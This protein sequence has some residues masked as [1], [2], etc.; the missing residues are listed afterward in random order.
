MS[1]FP[2]GLGQRPDLRDELLLA[3]NQLELDPLELTPA[4]VL[5]QHSGRWLVLADGDGEAARGQQGGPP[6][7]IVPARGRV[8][9]SERGQPVT[10]DW[11]AL[12]GGGAIAAVLPRHGEITRRAAGEVTRPQT[13]AANVDLALIAEP[14]GDVRLRRAER[15]AALA[16]AGGVTAALVLT[17]SDLDDDAYQ[18]AAGFARELGVPDGFAV[19]ATTGEGVGALRAA[20]VAGQTAVLLGASGAG[21]STLVNALLGS[22]QQAT[23]AVR[24]TDG[25]GRHTTVTRELLALP[26]GALLIDTPGIR[27]IGLWDEAAAPSFADIDELA[28]SCRF[29]DCQHDGE[30]GCAVQPAVDEAR[31][32]A[33]RKLRRERAW[34]DDRRAAERAREAS[35]RHYQRLQRE[36]RRGKGMDG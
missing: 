26:S 27:E 6:P 7:A 10:G 35:G 24:G 5:S 23:G 32:A 33:W 22:E 11:V 13:L 14:A 21:K 34:I 9:E 1:T 25:R 12:D 15:L 20:L 28:G 30:P 17:K 2:A 3:A 19:S 18:E 8:R 36:A 4:R 29:A 16:A 31:L